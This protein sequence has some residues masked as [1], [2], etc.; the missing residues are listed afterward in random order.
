MPSA[1]P[2]QPIDP[3]EKAV[4]V[5][6]SADPWQPID[7]TEKAVGVVPSADPWQPIDPTVLPQDFQIP[8][9]EST[10]TVPTRPHAPRW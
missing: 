5:V 6:P 3:T 7:P 8:I 2:W 4:G 9:P 1:D 10:Y